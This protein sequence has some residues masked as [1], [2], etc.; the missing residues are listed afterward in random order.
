MS[1]IILQSGPLSLLQDLGRF[2]HQDVGVTPGG[3]MDSHAFHWANR[4]LNN[5][6]H[7]GQIEISMGG[8]KARFSDACNF[9]V[10]GAQAPIT[11]NGT[12]LKHWSSHYAQPEDIIE[13]G[14]A[15]RGVRNYLAI[16]GGFLVPT[17]LGSCAT[18]MRDRL[19][20]LQQAGQK[21]QP[22]DTLP[23]RGRHRAV[24]RSVAQHFIPDYAHC[25]EIGVLPTYQFERFS[26]S[27]RQRFFS[28]EYTLTAQSDRMGYRLEGAPIN[29]QSEGFISEGIALG[30]IQIPSN[31][32]PIILLNDRQTIGG[33]PKIG[34]VCAKDL[35][36]LAQ[37]PPGTKIR[38]VLR[39][40]YRSEADL[41]IE[42]NYFFAD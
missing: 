27:A 28:S 41:Q 39:D 35:S 37:S 22:G 31:G 21:L 2:G 38:F 3:P 15:T 6:Q 4:L 25:V 40:L 7:S 33:Y 10:T 18:V 24:S 1:L 9:S 16:D 42:M 12:P 34:C 17:T 29:F 30:A 13:I 26:A 8:F 11:L 36:R 23:Y 32:Q 20:G 19:G 5:A 14:Y